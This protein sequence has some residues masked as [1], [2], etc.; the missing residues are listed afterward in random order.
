MD[1][2]GSDLRRLTDEKDNTSEVPGSFSPDGKR[3]A[4]TRLDIRS[5]VGAQ[6]P[7]LKGQL[8]VLD[9]AE[10]HE[11]Q[12]TDDGADPAF[13]PDGERIAFVSGRDRNGELNYGDRTHQAAELYLMRSDGTGQ[14]RLTR[15][16][17]LNEG[18]P[19]WLPDGT[20]LAYHR[21]EQTGNAEARAILQINPDGSCPT[22][23]LAD[24]HLSTWFADPAWRPGTL[25]S[26]GGPLR[27]A[28]RK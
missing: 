19:S 17:G 22:P 28:T 10:S 12:L 1:A 4:F 18:N 27:C 9:V 7:L 16:H 20:R 8:V 6:C 24:R 2:D 26:G 11:R 23:V 3:L 14:R 25:R 15:T 5:A 21:G 13:S